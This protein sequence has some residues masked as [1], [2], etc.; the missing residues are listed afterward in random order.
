MSMEF[1]FYPQ[2][3]YACPHIGHCPHLGGAALSTLVAAAS[4]EGQYLD[5]LHGQLDFERE[6]VAKLVTE[7]EELKRQLAQV[8]LELKLERQRQFTCGREAKDDPTDSPVAPRGNDKTAGKRGAPVGHPGWFRPTPTTCDEIVLVAAP[9]KCPHCGGDVRSFPNYESHD[10]LQEDVVNNTHQA[11]LYRHTPGRCRACRRWVQQ[12]GSGEVLGRRIGPRMRALAMYLRN[13]IGISYRKVPRALEEMFGFSFVPGSLIAFEKVLAGLA[14]PLAD[15]IAKKI[16]SSDGAV[17]ADETYWTLDGERAFYW[18]HAT[19]LYVHF[20]FDSSRAGE[21]SRA[22]LGDDFTGTLVTDCYSGYHAHQAKAKQK[23]LAHVARRAHEW[24]PLTVEGS[25]DYRFFEDVK[26]WVKRGCEFHRR[27]QLDQLS[28]EELTTEAAWLC[29][30]LSRLEGYALGHEKALTLQ[31]RLQ[32]HHDEW[33]VFVDD[34]RVPPTNNLA[35]QKLRPLVVLRKITFGHRT[36]AGARRMAKIMTI[37]ET[38]KAH[39]HKA[40]DFFYYLQTHS[41]ARSLRHL[42]SGP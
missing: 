39:G 11:V 21:V 2:H 34:P 31:A 5:M 9:R 25:A 36:E 12:A 20:Q 22:V 18:L 19:T 28:P 24:Q 33:L 38:A 35:E 10:H 30:E 27:R 23:C 1:C 26:Q 13:E 29:E 6:Q 14:E 41:T 4:E 37:K 42:Y 8:R 40:S 7:N 17:H 16:G 15:D 3:E 32:R